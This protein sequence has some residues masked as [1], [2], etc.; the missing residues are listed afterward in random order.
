MMGL[1]AANQIGW[2]EMRRLMTEEFC[3]VEEVQ[4]MEHELWNLKV[5]EFDITLLIL[6]AS[7]SG[8]KLNRKGIAIEGIKGNGKFTGSNNGNNKNNN[9]DNTRHNQQNNQRQGN[10]RAMTTAPAEQG[11]Y[12]VVGLVDQDAVI[13]CGKKVVHIP[14]KNKTMGLLHS[15]LAGPIA[16]VIRKRVYSSE[17]VTNGELHLLFVKKKDGSFPDVYFAPILALPEGTENFVVYCDASHKGYGAVLMQR[18]KVIAYA[19]RQLK[20]HEENYTTHD[21]ELGAVVF[22]LRL[23]RHYLYG[24]KCTMYTDHKSLQYI[25]DQKELNMRQRRWIELLSDYDCEI[26]YI[27]LV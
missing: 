8:S 13:V 1:E 7:M 24:T 4:R 19:S 17:L 20:K 25:L 21:L 16:R 2:T 9:R 14:V 22:A 3:P 12:L 10:A 18:E 5:K 11:S 15:D 23:W 6:M 27:L 26:R